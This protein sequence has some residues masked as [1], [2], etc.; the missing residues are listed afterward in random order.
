M[1]HMGRIIVLV[2]LILPQFLWGQGSREDLRIP[3]EL[4][5]LLADGIDAQQWVRQQ[6]ARQSAL[7]L[8]YERKL[9]IR[10]NFHLLQFAEEQYPAEEV[11]GWVRSQD[12][13][14][15]AQLSYEVE[16][17]SPPNDPEFN[18]QWDM[19]LIQAADVWGITEGGLTAQGDTIV[20]AIMDSGFEPSHPDLAANIWHN[21]AEIPGDGIDNDNNG[22][23]D[24]DMGWD[25]FSDTPNIAPGAHGL[26]ATGIIGAVGNNGVGVTG[27]NWHVKVMQFSFSAVPD[28][29]R[30]YEY[31]IDQRARYNESNGAE[32]AFVVAT[33]ASFGQARV[34]CDQQPAWAAMYDLMGEVGILTGGGAD[35][36]P[37]DVE[38]L[39]DMPTTCTTDYL[40]MTCNVNSDDNLAQGSAFGNVSVDIGSPGDGT[41]TIRP[42]GTYGV[43]GGNSAAAPHVTGAI[44]LMYSL[45]C[46]GIAA[47]ALD[48][49][50]TTALLIR[51]AILEGVDPN[52]SLAGKTVTGGRLNVFGS[53]EFV[54][55]QCANEPGPLSVTKVYPNP[56]S[57]A[58]LNVEY[59][60]PEF[61]DY[62]IE[63]F[64]PLGQ[65]IYRDV[66]DVPRFGERI[67][68][69]PTAQLPVGIYYLRFG[70]GEAVEVVPF[71]VYR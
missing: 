20:V 28:L 9:G 1:K 44:A 23:I 7:V 12:E 58:G 25:Y 41:I 66:V 51:Q 18:Q 22:Y 40:I 32:G 68:T 67:F 26:S 21:H 4:I 19:D 61:T 71:M 42:Q 65:I 13:V 43:Y 11:L 48:N 62:Q 69:V 2:A 5:I 36:S 14:V 39:G 8:E 56:T 54:Q 63:V 46:E 55:S 38:I 35:N 47:E 34:F 27:L 70:L 45:P 50:A 30:A 6:S 31:V 3:G 49:P 10:H 17:R 29:I 64:N 60:T 53:M 15:L 16:F 24:D 59:I 37:Y 33:N 57:D 52:E